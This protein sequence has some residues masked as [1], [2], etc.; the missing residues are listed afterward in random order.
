MSQ[1]ST[2]HTTAC[3]RCGLRY[4]CICTHRPILDS[5]TQIALLTHPNETQRATNTGKLLTHSLSNCQVHIWDRVNPPAELVKQI[6]EQPSYLL[7]PSEEAIEVSE[8]QAS[9]NTHESRNSPLFIILDG[10]WQEAKK[11]LNKSP[12]LQALPKVMLSSEQ[13]SNYRLR[14]NQEAGNLCTCEVGISL[15]Q[16]REPHKD[17]SSLQQ[18]FELF[19]KV[20]EADRQHLIYDFR[21]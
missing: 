3:P 9:I 6:T 13:T 17:F 19:L 12:W 7:F 16:Q 10:T 18:Y 1:Q 4:Q 15:L 20:Y 5:T 2:T 11:M 8:L 14:R 21:D